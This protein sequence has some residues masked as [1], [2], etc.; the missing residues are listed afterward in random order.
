MQPEFLSNVQQCSSAVYL[1]SQEAVQCNV[2]SVL[3]LPMFGDRG[4]L[5][6]IGVLEVAR[7]AGSTPTRNVVHALASAIE[8]RLRQPTAHQSHVAPEPS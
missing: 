8:V 5:V 7:S 4:R 6:P 3:L 1:R 2:R